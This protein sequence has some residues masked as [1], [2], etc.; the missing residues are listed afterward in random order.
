MCAIAD[1]A[2]GEW[3]E[4][5]RA[6]AKALCQVAAEED[7]EADI[8]TVLLADIRDIFARLSPPDHAAHEAGEPGGRTDGPRLLT[9]QLLDELIGL[10]ERPWSAWG[11]AQKATDGHRPCCAASALWDT[12]QPPFGAKEATGARATFCGPSRTPFP[13]T[14]PFPGFQPV[15]TVPNP[16]N[17]GENEDFADPCQIQFVTGRKMPETPAIPGFVTVGRVR[18]GEMGVWRKS[19]RRMTPNKT[20]RPSGISIHDGHERAR[21]GALLRRPVSPQARRSGIVYQADAAPPPDVV[22]VLAAAK[23]DFLRVLAGREAAKSRDSTPSA[24]PDCLPRTVD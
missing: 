17:T 7:V 6:A 16:G 9:K 3:P 19:K 1:L 21:A 15:H 8:K 10:E 2:G 5:A 20:P 11:K 18:R 22:A 13:A 14:C 23:P 24:P 12:V 4:R